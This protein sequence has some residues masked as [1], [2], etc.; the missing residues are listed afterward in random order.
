MHT[1]ELRDVVAVV[2]GA[3]RGIGRAIAR[4]LSRA[5]AAVALVARSE[6][7]LAE[8]AA[9][10]DRML[11]LPA[12]VRDAAAVRYLMSE[13]DR[14]FGPVTLLVNNAATAGPVGADWEVDADEWWEG[15]ESAVRGTFLCSQAVLPG[16]IERGS[17][18]IVNLASVTGTQPFPYVSATSVAKT[19]VLRLTEGLA[20][21]AGQFGVRV[22]AINPGVVETEITRSYIDS[23]DG[24]RWMP[25]IVD[26]VKSCW[27][28]PEEVG[29]GDLVLALAA[30]RLDELSGRLISV[31]DDVAELAARA[32]D[33]VAREA[34]V[35]RLS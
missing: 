13:A 2:T 23:P 30:G 29:V 11:V 12:D 27:Q 17:G 3:G 6:K 24:R 32:P 26:W 5:G 1:D 7:E 25:D 31:D 33:I 21:S 22:F 14:A 9:G 35:L 19:A 15:I 34:L 28:T 4:A 16:M 20:L 18:R 10:T 8:T